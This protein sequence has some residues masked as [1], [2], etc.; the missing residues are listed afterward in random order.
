MGTRKEHIPVSSLL[1]HLIELHIKRP[2][3]RDMNSVESGDSRAVSCSQHFGSSKACDIDNEKTRISNGLFNYVGQEDPVSCVIEHYRIHFNNIVDFVKAEYPDIDLH[4]VNLK[5]DEDELRHISRKNSSS[6]GSY[7]GN[8]KLARPSPQ[9]D[10]TAMSISSDDEI[11]NRAVVKAKPYH[12]KRSMLS[13]SSSDE[14]G[15][16]HQT[17]NTSRVKD[18][19][20]TLE[21]SNGMS[22]GESCTD[23]INSPLKKSRRIRICAVCK[24]K[25]DDDKFALHV[26]SHTSL[27]WEDEKK[28]EGS[29]V[30]LRGCGQLLPNWDKQAFHLA[31]QHNELLDKLKS[32]GESL[33]DFEGDPELNDDQKST[34][35]GFSTL[36]S[37]I[38]RNV[39][40]LHNLPQ[41]D[42]S[43]EEI[44]PTDILSNISLNEIQNP[45]LDSNQLHHPSVVLENVNEDID[46]NDLLDDSQVSFSKGP[47]T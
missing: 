29:Q 40:D 16:P 36:V 6:E 31:I 2:C 37:S 45:L 3:V 20:G 19:S 17:N 8:F 28:I 18:Q 25:I 41:D 44:I 43:D 38:K 7:D 10:N 1:E 47:R 11:V 34:V 35:D 26:A 24:A 33:S 5:F 9:N 42:S 14:G 21:A 27:Y 39:L 12:R 13:S 23:K 32:R 46:V 30:C 4:E 22:Q 15:G